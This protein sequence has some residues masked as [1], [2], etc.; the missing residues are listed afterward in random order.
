MSTATQESFRENTEVVQEKPQEATYMIRPNY[1]KKF[2]KLEVAKII[3]EVLKNTLEGQSFDSDQVGSWTTSISNEVKNR[4]KELEFERYK[5]VVQCL[6]GEQ[7]GA[8]AKMGCRCFWDSDTDNYAQELFT[9]STLFCVTAV[10]G[11][12][13][14]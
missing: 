12:Y 6:I 4:C 2:K 9:N 10:F 1:N 13:Y 14:Y 7:R 11:V 8:G 5:I 3:T